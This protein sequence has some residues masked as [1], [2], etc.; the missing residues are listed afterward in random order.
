MAVAG[1]FLKGNF[2]HI[3]T[4]EGTRS[5]HTFVDEDFN[6]V[7]LEK[8]PTQKS[9]SALSDTINKYIE[10][11]KITEIII[12]RRVTAGQMAGAAGSFLW[13]GILLTMSPVPLRFVHT[14]TVRATE[15][16]NGDLKTLKPEEDIPLGKAYDFAFEGL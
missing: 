6:K 9:V 7:E 5:S 13:E 10:K 11:N 2:A 1:I 15:K 4:L 3:V 16:K 8:N 12:N 14:A